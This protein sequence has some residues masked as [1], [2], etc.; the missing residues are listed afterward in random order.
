MSKNGLEFIA[1]LSLLMAACLGPEPVAPSAQW[2]TELDELDNALLAV[3]PLDAAHTDLISVGGPLRGNAAPSIFRRSKDGKW[4]LLRS[5][6]GFTGAIWWSW[7]D[8]KD[9]VWMVGEDLQIAHGPIDKM[10][11]VAAPFVKTATKATLYG[12]WGSGP[13]DVWMVG[14]SPLY[15]D[16]PEGV[17][18]HY[19][20]ASIRKI[21]PTGTASV[22]NSETFFK[23]WGT[24]PDDVMIV[25]TN[26]TAL[27]FDGRNWTLTETGTNN[28]LLTVHGRSAYEMYAVG[29]S[30]N[31]SVLQF[32]GYRWRDIGD[33][34]MPFLN[35]VFAA[36]DGTVWV[37][38]PAA[39]V[40]QWD[41]QNW[42]E[43]DIGVLGRDLHGIFASEQGVF[44][45]G[46][47]LAIQSGPRM[48][49]LMRFGL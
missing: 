43:Y 38:G 46:G 27:H 7:A 30:F 37:C 22:A 3:V 5:P 21:E 29:G 49:T 36:Q 14:G 42:I 33:E 4:D 45:A 10:E 6:P 25:G 31:G 12:V 17:I 34:N 47:I 40:A 8:S 9:D 2:R 11:L 15:A 19:D 28:R 39:Y 24:G 23:V 26:G 18:F 13:N 48:G 41:G 20:G 1:G 32:D 16:G 44:S 35:G